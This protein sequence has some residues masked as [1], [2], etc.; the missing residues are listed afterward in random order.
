[1]TDTELDA[2]VD[3]ICEKFQGPPKCD[4]LKRDATVCGGPG[5]RGGTRCSRHMKTKPYMMCIAGCGGV[6]SSKHGRPS[7]VKCKPAPDKRRIVAK[8]G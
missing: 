6:V 4:Y 8:S 7:C 3:E 1:M 5:V 2:V